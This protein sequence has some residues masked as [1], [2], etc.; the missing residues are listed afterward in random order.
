MTTYDM[1]T[2]L[3]NITGRM[4]PTWE[5]SVPSAGTSRSQRGNSMYS[6]RDAKELQSCRHTLS[7]LF[8]YAWSMARACLE[9]GKSMPR[10]WVEYGMMVILLMFVGVGEV[11]GEDFTGIWYIANETNH[12]NTDITTH[13]Y[14]VPGRDPQ[15]PHYA[16]AYFNNQFCNISGSGDYT[17]DNYGDPGKPFL[18]TYQTSQDL[19]SVWIIVST[20][21]GYYNIIHARTGKYVVYEPPYQDA[22]QRKSVHLE[23]TTTPGDN[24][25]FT[26]NGS[27]SGPININP[28]NIT[29]GNMYFNPA[30]SDGNYPRYYGTED[31]YFHA[32]MIGL[33]SAFGDK[34]QW[35]FEKA[36]PIITFAADGKVQ[37]NSSVPS[38]ISSTIY[39]RTDGTDPTT[40]DA[41]YT[42][43]FTPDE[44]ATCFKAIVVINDVQSNVACVP[45]LPG[46]ARTFLLQSLGYT[47]DK[48]HDGFFL[49][50]GDVDNSGNITLTT[51]SVA[52]P[53]MQWYLELAGNDSD[54]QYYYFVNPE[55]GNYLYCD[56][57]GNVLMKTDTDF[58][59]ESNDYKFY[60]QTDASSGYRIVPKA[61]PTRWINKAYGH[62]R[63][64]AVN[65]SASVTDLSC[66]W[67]FILAFDHK[68][69]IA[70]R[71]TPFT[72]SNTTS[73]TYYKIGN[74]SATEYFIVPGTTNV[75]TSNTE[76]DNMAWYFKEAE[77]DDWLTYYHIVN[78]KTGL[79]MYF[80]GSETATNNSNAFITQAISTTEKDRYQFVVAK[81]QTSGSDGKYYIVP[82][83]LKDLTY[84]NYS[85]VWR[86]GTNAL[87]T[88]A[89]RADD[90]RKWTF[91]PTPLFCNDPEF[92]V[93]DGEIH[94][95]CVPDITRIYYTTDGTEPNTNDES[96]RYRNTKSWSVSNKL[97]IKAKAVVKNETTSAPQ[98]PAVFTLL[99][100]P[101]V[102]LAGGPY[103]YQGTAWEPSVT[104]S[105]GT[106]E[107][108]TT[109]PTNPATYTIAYSDNINA[110]T[111]SVTVTDANAN[112]NWYLWNIPT[113]TFTIDKA[114][115]T[116]TVDNVN[117][118]YGDPIPTYTATYTGS[119]NEEIDP[120]FAPEPTFSCDYTPTSPAGSSYSITI[121]GGEAPNYKIASSTPG[122]LTVGKKSIG[123][124]S[125][126]EGFT[127]D[128]GT[129]NTIIL[130]DGTKELTLNNDYTDEPG[131]TTINPD[132]YS[133]RTIT[134]A[135]NYEG[136]FDILNAIA[137]FGTD[138]SE[139]SATF[140][141]ET[142]NTYFGHTLPSDISAYIITGIEGSWAIPEPL[143]YIPTGIPVLL[144]ANVKKNGFVVTNVNKDDVSQEV[145]DA[146]GLK[147]DY[148]KLKEV[149][150]TTSG[151]VTD[152]E[153]EYYQKAHFSTKQ[154]YVLYNNEFVL[155]KDGYLDKGKVYME[156]PSWVDPN[157]GGGGGGAPARLKI[158]WDEASGMTELRNDESTEPQSGTGWYT[159]DGR[160][161][162]GKPSAKGLY[163]VDGKKIMVK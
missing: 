121:S 93:T 126:A 147:K 91:T 125:L 95:S 6:A 84:N 16:D 47:S 1:M 44:D 151:Y 45:V 128:F 32:G 49:Q 46:S 149:T 87:K 159:I 117:V 129:G 92:T 144:V 136:T 41:Q 33:Y 157:S 81:T 52:R 76:S 70:L 113:K 141:A 3:N 120:G 54:H 58:D 118:S 104:V 82:K 5:Q 75:T 111:A 12:S 50:P 29:S 57:S 135:G 103:T 143:D 108:I 122:T 40:T 85:L 88:Q 83:V 55:S 155:N 14:L 7:I 116:A 163:I 38:T 131:A 51:S 94:I 15:Q 66:R 97:R 134:G 67:E 26:I 110:G 78:A 79:Y 105:I 18:T 68:M 145:K 61:L 161:L 53:L 4:F 89:Q 17:G 90:N 13:W 30:V 100:K 39:Y 162:N 148:N 153:S 43:E 99:N 37:I 137:T 156:N 124:G 25:K 80:N 71:P 8:E 59:A 60:L 102:T 154:I 101:N 34:S 139:W 133:S 127:L 31:D 9:Y 21:D 115:L 158:K 98:L 65:T 160:K 42:S 138:G 56:A 74:A 72:V 96:Q 142:E 150:N 63:N 106:G 28:K 73:A 64:E 27:L 2:G 146:Y 86:D 20:D 62:N 22:T 107:T 114:S 112:D 130:K 152:T 19:N 119:A 36:S 10:V 123:E 24:A 109:A 69:P 48:P 35:Y 11:W 23:S 132:K 77:S 140:V